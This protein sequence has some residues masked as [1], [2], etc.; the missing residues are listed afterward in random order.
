[1]RDSKEYITKFGVDQKCPTCCPI[2]GCDSYEPVKKNI[3]GILSPG[4]SIRTLY[5]VCTGCGVMFQDPEK[6]FKE[7]KRFQANGPVGLMI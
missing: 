5:Y 4:A 1:M 6:F 2:C 3:N 7:P